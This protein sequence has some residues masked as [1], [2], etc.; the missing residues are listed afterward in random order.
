MIAKVTRNKEEINLCQKRAPNGENQ[1]RQ[2]FFGG[3]FHVCYL[4]N[5]ST[6]A[7][8]LPCDFQRPD[9]HVTIIEMRR[10]SNDLVFICHVRFKGG[11]LILVSFTLTSIQILHDKLKLKPTTTADPHKQP[12]TMAAKEDVEYTNISFCEMNET[13]TDKAIV[14]IKDIINQHRKGVGFSFRNCCFCLFYL[15]SSVC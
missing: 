12:L 2:D 4:H 1:V 3:L 10:R 5:N 7:S 13:D 9:R 14:L 11:R 6:G 8:F 15:G